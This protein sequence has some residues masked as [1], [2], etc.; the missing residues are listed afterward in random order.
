MSQ[1]LRTPLFP[2]YEQY[3]GVRC[4]DFGG[5][6]LPV[7][8]SGIQKEHEAVRQ[9]AGLFDVSH[10]GEFRIEGAKAEDFLQGMLTNDVSVLE[11]GQAQYT[12]MCY[13]TGGVVDDL[14]VYKRSDNLYMLVVNASNIDKDWS[15]LQEHLPE[16]VQMVNESEA[17]ALLALQG[18]H[19][20]AI[21]SKVTN[22]NLAELGS[23]RFVDGAD[24]CGSKVILSRTGYTGEDGFE[25]YV[26]AEEA[27]N[28]WKELM[29]AG[30]NDGLIPIGLGARDTLRFEARLPL[31]GQELSSTIT[32]LEA[33]L[34]MFVKLAAG[35]FIGRDALVKQKE[36]G[37]TRKL[38]GIE[39]TDRGIPRSHYP[40]YAEGEQIGEVTTGTQSPTLKRNLGLALLDIR[41]TD[42]GTSVEV[43]I[44]GKRLKAEI[45]KT[46]F[47]RRPKP[48]AQEAKGANE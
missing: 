46:P 41:Y 6:E 33:G 16:G 23:F 13:P 38:V 42:P 22:V 7:S 8:F 21:L 30:D 31:Y 45:V 40:V 28:V 36:E 43:E 37:L 10:M 44:R 39:I 32:P 27:Q 26:N 3:P 15:W 47:Y 2:L 5:W 48:T 14:L 25:I 29:A 35:E 24:V 4:I 34:G 9:Q 12:L 19:A 17:T 18:P 1:L 11:I 20:E